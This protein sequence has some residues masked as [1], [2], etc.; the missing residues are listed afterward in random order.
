MRD[1]ATAARVLSRTCITAAVWGLPA[2]AATKP[3]SLC[4]ARR[5]KPCPMA[6]TYFTIVLVSLFRPTHNGY[7]LYK[8]RGGQD[9]GANG[10]ELPRAETVRGKT[11]TGLAGDIQWPIEVSGCVTLEDETSP[12]SQE[13]YM[14]GG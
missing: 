8:E 5:D 13:G 4:S 2:G 6:D 9:R 10:A 7:M 3:V 11:L 12:T 14:R 1:R